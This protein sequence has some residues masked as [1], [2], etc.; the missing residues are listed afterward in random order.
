MTTAIGSASVVR[1]TCR[2]VGLDRNPM[3]R[4]IDRVQSLVGAMLIMVFLISAP[5]LAIS[6]GGRVYAE[7]DRVVRAQIAQLHQIDATVI[8]IGKTSLYAPITSARVQWLD[9][10]GVTR[11]ADYQSS[12]GVKPGATVQIWLDQNGNIA[13]PPVPSRPMSKA[14]VTTTALVSVILT[15]CCVCHLLLRCGLDR[16]R[17]RLWET[18][19]ATVQRSWGNNGT[20]PDQN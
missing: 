6:V 17:A 3:R 12:T 5:L 13:A 2:R 11:T 18:E 16:R 4:R 20:R 9:A 10:A 15:C 19:W 8:E 7:E 14:V 1:R